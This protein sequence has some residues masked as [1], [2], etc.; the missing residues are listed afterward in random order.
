MKEFLNSGF[1]VASNGFGDDY[2]IEFPFGHV[3]TFE[4]ESAHRGL[5]K[6]IEIAPTSILHGFCFEYRC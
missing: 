2:W 1:P 5:L 4:H 3:R 6:I